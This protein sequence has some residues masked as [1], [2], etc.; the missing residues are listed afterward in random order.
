M[1]V[2]RL[3]DGSDRRL[4]AYVK[5]GTLASTGW[6]QQHA[7]VRHLVLASTATF[8]RIGI[9]RGDNVFQYKDGALTA[10]FRA[11]TP[12]IAE[13]AMTGPRI[14]TLL[15]DGSGTVRSDTGG[16]I[17]PQIGRIAAG[18]SRVTLDTGR[19]CHV[20]GDGL[21]YCNNGGLGAVFEVYRT[22]ANP[23]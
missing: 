4:R 5:D 14:A 10:A 11:G 3:P 13:V 20:G 19:I 9:L 6:V 7:N 18:S 22:K 8:K 2:L 17:P 15:A 12:A 1:P 21:G 16:T 23:L